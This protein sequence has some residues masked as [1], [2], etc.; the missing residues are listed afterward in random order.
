MFWLDET[1][2]HD[3]NLI[4]KVNEYL[5][6]HDTDGLDIR[7][8]NPVDATQFSLDRIREG[9][10]TISVTGNVLRDYNTDLFPT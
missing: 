1:R 3:R 9:K 10:D 4:E 8:M 7:I 5:K 6:E 2:A